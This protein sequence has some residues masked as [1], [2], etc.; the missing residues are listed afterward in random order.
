MLSKLMTVFAPEA[1]DY[2]D[3]RLAIAGL[4][5]R[6]ARSDGTYAASEITRIDRL[7]AARYGLTAAEAAALRVEAEEYEANAPDTVRFTRAI[8]ENV[9]LD[10]RFAVVEDLWDVVL[11]DGVR[12]ESE[13]ALMRLL[14]NLLGINDRDSALCRQRVLARRNPE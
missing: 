8:K 9:P 13:D 2:G 4:M 12:D 14:A 3:D 11:E 5:V 1:P 7:L 6:L 10:E